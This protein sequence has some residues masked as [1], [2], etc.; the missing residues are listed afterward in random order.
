LALHE[1]AHELKV[2]RL[3][4]LLLKLDF[5]KAYDRINWDFLQEALT[6]KGFGHGCS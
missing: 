6:R 3:G 5:E 2:K 1:I 4:S